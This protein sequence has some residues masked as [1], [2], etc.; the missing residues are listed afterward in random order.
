MQTFSSFIISVE[1][2]CKNA[3]IIIITDIGDKYE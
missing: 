1:I 3:I 2:F